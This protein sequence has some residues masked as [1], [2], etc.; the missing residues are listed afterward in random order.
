MQNLHAYGETE[1]KQYWMPDSVSRECYEC[2][3]KFTTFRRRHHC[4]ICG[5]IFCSQCCSQKIPGKIFGCS[6]DLRACTYCCKI[7]LSYL[8]S[9]D[10]GAHLTADLRALQEDLQSKFGN[11]ASGQT[12]TQQSTVTHSNKDNND[13]SSVRR[14]ISI[15]YQEEKF[16]LGRSSNTNYISTEERIRILRSSVSLRNLY[17]ELCGNSGLPL[18]THRYRLRSFSDCFLGS[19]IVDWLILQCKASTRTQAS[20]LCQALLEAGYMKCLTEQQSGPFCDGDFLYRPQALTSPELPP[21]EDKFDRHQDEPSWMQQVPHESSTTDSEAEFSSPCID[22]ISFR[23]PSS[24]SSYMLDFNLQDNSVHLTKPPNLELDSQNKTEIK[25]PDDL[26]T[27]DELN[28]V[29]TSQHRE[30]APVSGLYVL[31]VGKC[32]FFHFVTTRMGY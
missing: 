5:Q 21:T 30:H 27:P 22:K 14:R 17:D 3:E 25:P 18:Q 20:S 19:E 23:L 32:F 31:L 15:G 7:V 29:Q 24:S 16:S 6:G 28:I 10:I 1:L 9:P 12:T 4:R 2:T 13:T 8:Q 26:N 11:T